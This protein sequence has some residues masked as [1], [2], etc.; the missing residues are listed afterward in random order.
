MKPP[1]LYYDS[2]DVHDSE[3]TA[4]DFDATLDRIAGQ[5]E[6]RSA[7][8]AVTQVTFSRLDRIAAFALAQ[9]LTPAP[10]IPR[11]NPAEHPRLR[12]AFETY[13]EQVRDQL[14]G[15]PVSLADPDPALLQILDD[16]DRRDSPGERPNLLRLLGMLADDAFIGPHTFHLDISNRCNTNC[17]FCGLHSPMLKQPKRKIQGRRF[18]EGW[19]GRLVDERI[20]TELVDDLAEIGTREDLLFSG[21]G[22]PLTH[23]QAPWMIRYVKSRDIALTLF[24]NGLA[25]NERLANMLIDVNLDILYWSLS[26]ATPASFVKQQPARRES[27]FRRV[28]DV[29]TNLVRRK[30]KRENK[31]YLI[32]AHVINNINYDECEKAMELAAQIGVDSVRYQLMHSCSSTEPLL[33]GKEQFERA[34]PQIDRA[35][36]LAEQAGIDIVANIDFQLEAAAKTFELPETVL[37]CHWSHDLYNRTGCLAGWL[38]SRSFTDGRISF[39]C[40]DKIVGNLYRGRYKDLWFSDRYRRIRRK[41]KAFNLKDNIDLTDERCGGLLLDEDCSYCGNYEFINQALS[42]LSDLGWDRFLRKV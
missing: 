38:F 15:T 27:D 25:L 13:L 2:A 40:H 14:R 16:F 34:A 9:T 4:G 30:R 33:I 12:A 23:P 10:K 24:T 32:L 35:R 21:E 5:S 8:V 42:D 28:V 18:T 17:V 22:E 31:P 19:K 20:F 37:P 11:F 26:A 7:R 39:C 36:L 29:M 3:T 41:A 1:L 6:G